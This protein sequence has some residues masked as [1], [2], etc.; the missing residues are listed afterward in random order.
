MFVAVFVLLRFHLATFGCWGLSS[1]LFETRAD[2]FGFKVWGASFTSLTRTETFKLKRSWAAEHEAGTWPS[3][4]CTS[5]TLGRVSS[6]DLGNALFS[7]FHWTRPVCTE[8]L[9]TLEYAL[10]IAT[11]NLKEQ[12]SFASLV[13]P[14]LPVPAAFLRGLHLLTLRLESL[15]TF[16]S[17]NRHRTD[18]C[19][20]WHWTTF[21][22]LSMLPQFCTLAIEV[23]QSR[24]T[25]AH[26]QSPYSMS[27]G[28]TQ[29]VNVLNR[30]SFLT[31][32]T[33]LSLWS[34]GSFDWIIRM[35]FAAVLT[36]VVQFRHCRLTRPWAFV[37]SS[38]C[39][40]SSEMYIWRQDKARQVILLSFLDEC[41]WLGLS[42]DPVL[43]LFRN[44]QWVLT[45]DK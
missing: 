14:A 39:L 27:W 23:F 42:F 28:F 10:S 13:R 22:I 40:R 5:S 9:L 34:P 30:F 38:D 29:G 12:N 15:V 20:D 33:F 16:R 36:T 35:P 8:M 24:K 37:H 7:F 19:N 2:Y 25:A 17:S 26:W 3:L 21:N 11:A 6:V 41:S 32:L 31:T 18:S 45:E 43:E 1:A 44:L 4:V